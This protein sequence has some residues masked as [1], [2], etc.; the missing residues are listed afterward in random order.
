MKKE[1]T[2]KLI[3]KNG[4]T[5]REEAELVWNAYKEKEAEAELLLILWAEWAKKGL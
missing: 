4:I 1:K 5:S 3:L 2:I